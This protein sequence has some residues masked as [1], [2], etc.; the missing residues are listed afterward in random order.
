MSWPHVSESGCQL[1]GE[2]L[3]KFSISC[4][5]CRERRDLKVASLNLKL[6]QVVCSNLM[7]SF[8]KN[9]FSFVLWYSSVGS[10]VICALPQGSSP[11]LRVDFPSGFTVDVLP[12]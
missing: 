11:T 8:L 5:Q 10:G 6:S 9:R 1:V 7:F 12:S 4:G 2:K 3:G